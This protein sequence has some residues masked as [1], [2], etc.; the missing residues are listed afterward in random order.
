M[1]LSEM[2]AIVIRM[3]I[4]FGLAYVLPMT[5]RLCCCCLFGGGVTRLD[6][7][8]CCGV[9]CGVWCSYWTLV[10][11]ACCLIRLVTLISRGCVM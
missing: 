7:F 10:L 8:L 2:L 6:L 9:A 3:L 4:L 11:V 5:V 1:L